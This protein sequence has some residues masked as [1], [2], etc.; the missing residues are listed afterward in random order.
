MLDLDR[1]LD[2]AAHAGRLEQA[3]AAPFFVR[4]DF[5]SLDWGDACVQRAMLTL[6]NA[7]CNSATHASVT[8][9]PNRLRNRRDFS[10]VNFFS[11]PSL[12]FVCARLSVCRDFSAVSSSS[13]AS[14]TCVLLMFSIRS[15]F[16]RANSFSPA[17]P[18][19][20]AAMS[21]A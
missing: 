21:S 1:L 18:T 13:A 3:V 12:T 4:H 16:T 17:S 11:P 7:L 9:V 8:F 5:A 15:V 19:F 6:G 20:V 10:P 14:V 2:H